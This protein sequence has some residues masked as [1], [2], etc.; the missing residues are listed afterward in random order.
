MRFPAVAVVVVAVVVVRVR[1]GLPVLRVRRAR[2][3]LMGRRG[4]RGRKGLPVFRV[5]LVL[6]FGLRVRS[7]RWLSCPPPAMF[8]ATCG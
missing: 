1:R 3:V 6:G 2:R 5:S 4:R 8:T 7:L